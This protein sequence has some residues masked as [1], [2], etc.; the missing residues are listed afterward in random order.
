[1]NFVNCLDETEDSVICEIIKCFYDFRPSRPMQYMTY[2]E[3]NKSK[4]WSIYCLVYT[5]Q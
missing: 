4:A 5:K 2:E 1:M 3:D